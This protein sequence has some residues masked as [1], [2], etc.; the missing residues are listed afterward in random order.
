MQVFL[1]LFIPLSTQAFTSLEPAK[2]TRVFDKNTQVRPF[3]EG[4]PFSKYPEPSIETMDYQMRST[5]RPYPPKPT[6]DQPL[7]T[8]DQRLTTIVNYA[9]QTQFQFPHRR[10]QSIKTRRRHAGNQ[11]NTHGLPDERTFFELF[12]FLSI[13][14]FTSFGYAGNT[15]IFDT[16]TG[17]PF[18]GCAHL[19]LNTRNRGSTLWL[20]SQQTTKQS[21]PKAETLS[22][23]FLRKNWQ[24]APTFSRR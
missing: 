19:F 13:Q 12:L 2:N 3:I 14:A 20:Q 9:K 4:R 16:N 23:D 1:E 7:T 8:N 22:F 18:M 24:N 10:S 15:R 5:K 21:R 6:R 11:S 17:P